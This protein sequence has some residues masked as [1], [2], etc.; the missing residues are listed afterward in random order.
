MLYNMFVGGKTRAQH[1]DM[2]RCWAV[3]K[4]LHNM[5]AAGQPPTNMLYNKVRFW[6]ATNEHV[7][8]HVVQS[9]R[10]VEYDYNGLKDYKTTTNHIGCKRTSAP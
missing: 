10:L 2:S 8:Q 7:G 3:T 5:F 9:V 6:S 4:L 1:L